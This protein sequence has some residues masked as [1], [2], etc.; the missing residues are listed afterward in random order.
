MRRFVDVLIVLSL[1][2]GAVA[3]S[4]GF[5]V[6]GALGLTLGLLLTWKRPWCMWAF[7]EMKVTCESSAHVHDPVDTGSLEGDDHH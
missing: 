7:E 4:L 2:A 5:R 3:L 6:A 1:L